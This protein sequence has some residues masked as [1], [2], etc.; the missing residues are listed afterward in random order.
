[1]NIAAFLV[2]KPIST[3]LGSGLVMPRKADS[4]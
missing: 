2:R 4:I 1:M 3:L